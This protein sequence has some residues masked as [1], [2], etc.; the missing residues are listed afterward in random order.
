MLE[1]GADSKA[2]ESK[3]LSVK[4]LF[5]KKPLLQISK[6]RPTYHQGR[7]HHF[8]PNKLSEKMGRRDIQFYDLYKLSKPD[9]AVEKLT[10]KSYALEGI[11]RGQV[12]DSRGNVL[13][14]LDDD[15]EP[16]YGD[17]EIDDFNKLFRNQ[18][19]IRDRFGESISVKVNVTSSGTISREVN[20][21][22]SKAKIGE[23]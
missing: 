3:D 6:L 21:D 4:Q 12:R 20:E 9:D 15:E 11:L 14:D 13:V 5:S 16:I 2:T 22:L 8:K 17:I 18:N 10:D 19:L 23:N 1:S 7:N